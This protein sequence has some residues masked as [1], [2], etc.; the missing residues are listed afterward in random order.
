MRIALHRVPAVAR[1][2]SARRQS[3][4]IAPT[5]RLL[6]RERSR[7][8]V[9]RRRAIRSSRQILL[10]HTALLLTSLGD[11]PMTRALVLGGG[12]FSGIAW[13]LGVLQGLSAAGISVLD[14]DLVVGTSAGAFVGSRVLAADAFDGINDS[15]TWTPPVDE[16]GL[17]VALGSTAVRAI[18]LTRRPIFRWVVPALIAW[19]AVYAMERKA[20]RHGFGDVAKLQRIPGMRR[21]GAV[22]S[23]KLLHLVGSLARLAPTPPQ[24]RWISYWESALDGAGGWPPRDLVIA[25]VSTTDGTRAAWNRSDDVPIARAVAAS[26]S[27]PGL[28]QPVTIGRSHYIDAGGHSPTNADLATGHDHVL[29]VAP[30]DRGQLA[31]EAERLG[32]AGS[33]VSIVRPSTGSRERL[34][35]A[36]G[37]LLDVARTTPSRTAGEAD[38]RAAA[39][40]LRGAGWH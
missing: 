1:A 6:S 40:T 35:V 25:T 32:A 15:R 22:P 39:A 3:G 5:M 18:R 30:V 17:A 38:G 11:D 29:V 23:A 27:I 10:P 8:S 28:C 4:L 33:T 13:E 24:E 7:E 34:G 19:R 9:R 20:A 16:T 14:C 21:E 31:A 37:E 2:S 36:I 12:G 26:T